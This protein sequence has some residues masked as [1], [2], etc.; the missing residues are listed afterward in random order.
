MRD[1]IFKRHHSGSETLRIIC[2]GARMKAATPVSRQGWLRMG[3]AGRR[4]GQILDTR[5]DIF[6][7]RIKRIHYKSECRI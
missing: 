1:V 6:E 5:I 4:G 7:D 2:R 3:G